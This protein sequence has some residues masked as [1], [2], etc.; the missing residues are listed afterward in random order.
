MF[1]YQLVSFAQLRKEGLTAPSIKNLYAS[2]RLF[3]TPF[4]GI[5]YVPGEDERASW[6]IG[7]PMRV[8]SRAIRLFLGN[9]RFYYTGSVAE[10]KLGLRWQPTRHV[11]VVN[12]QFARRVDLRARI[13]RSERKKTFRAKKIAR[14]LEF[15]GDEIVFHKVKKFEKCHFKPTPQGNYATAGQVKKDAERFGKRGR[16]TP[17]PD[18]RRGLQGR[19]KARR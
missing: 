16:K 4:K 12:G 10:Q 7:S 18:E 5:Y 8:L 3:P 6:S 13:G 9:E 1:S 15:Y 2:L 14:L 17:K 11:H 19:P